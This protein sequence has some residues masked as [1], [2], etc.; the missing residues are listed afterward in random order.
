MKMNKT[1]QLLSVLFLGL[2]ITLTLSSCSDE[3]DEMQVIYGFTTETE[4]DM[5]K[6]NN[7]DDATKMASLFFDKKWFMTKTIPGETLEQTDAKA[8][9]MFNSIVNKANLEIVKMK[10]QCCTHLQ[11]HQKKC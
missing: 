11:M 2:V 4:T 8:K 3:D 9:E 6:L 1:I 5:I 7:T 10:W